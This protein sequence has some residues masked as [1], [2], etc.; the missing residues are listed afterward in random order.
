MANIKIGINGFGRIGRLVARVATLAGDV[1]IVGINDPFMDAE[2]GS[3]LFSLDTTHGEFDGTV[4]AKD[5]NLIINLLQRHSPFIPP[6]R[7][8]RTILSLTD[9]RISEG[10]GSRSA[11]L[12]IKHGKT[13]LICKSHFTL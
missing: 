1:T 8:N 3:Y 12:Q 6:K 13:C 11:R 2:Y 5:N 4:S 7:K 9:L 10:K